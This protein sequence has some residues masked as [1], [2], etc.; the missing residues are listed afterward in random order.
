MTEEKE[1]AATAPRSWWQELFD[2][3]RTAKPDARYRAD[4]PPPIVAPEPL[5]S[6]PEPEGERSISATCTTTAPT[7]ATVRRND[8][9]MPL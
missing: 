5:P 4:K 7:R 6:E 1:K 9:D 3:I 8:V 2:H